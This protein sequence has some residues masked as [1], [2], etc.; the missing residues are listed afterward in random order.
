MNNRQLIKIKHMARILKPSFYWHLT[1]AKVIIVTAKATQKIKKWAVWIMSLW[2]WWLI[3]L[4]VIT[5]E[6]RA[7]NPLS[8][9]L[10][11]LVHDKVVKL[12]DRLNSFQRYILSWVLF[13]HFLFTGHHSWCTPTVGSQRLGPETLGKY[14]DVVSIRKVQTCKEFL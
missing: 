3:F 5:N 14:V 11:L 13:F 4:I 7:I 10:F 12:W 9:L 2:H 8:H 6:I 1:V